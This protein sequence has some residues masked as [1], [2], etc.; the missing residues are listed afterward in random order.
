MSEEQGE[1]D[2]KRRALSLRLTKQAIHD[3]ITNPEGLRRL[4]AISD[5]EWQQAVDA[6]DREST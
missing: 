6:D 3:L 2:K 5:E 1:K 4:R